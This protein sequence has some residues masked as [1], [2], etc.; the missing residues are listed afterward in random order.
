MQEVTVN[1]GK[2]RFRVY[3]KGNSGPVVWFL[4]G[5]GFS[6]LT[7]SLLSQSLVQKV[8]C[9]FYCMDIRGHGSTHTDNDDDLSI[10]TLTK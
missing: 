6:A 4:H 9:Q 8:N 3:T 10:E 7:W 2:Q 1:D 5:G